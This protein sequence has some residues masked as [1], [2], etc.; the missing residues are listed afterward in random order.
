MSALFEEIKKHLKDKGFK[1]TDE[2][3]MVLLNQMKERGWI[4]INELDIN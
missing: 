1:V 3:L 2:D 4:K